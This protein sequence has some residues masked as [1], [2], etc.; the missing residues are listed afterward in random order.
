M[1]FAIDPPR[2]RR[3]T[4]SN[5][6]K[7]GRYTLLFQKS[8]ARMVGIAVKAKVP[9]SLFLIW[10]APQLPPSK[11]SSNLRHKSVENWRSPQGNST[12]RSRRK[13]CAKEQLSC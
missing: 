6:P 11:S 13:S 5:K 1:D 8:R 3:A 10:N 2:A 7:D 9:C 12:E 4:L